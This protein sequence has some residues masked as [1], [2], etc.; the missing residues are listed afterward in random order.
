KQVFSFS[1]FKKETSTKLSSFLHFDNEFNIGDPSFRKAYS[2]PSSDDD[3]LSLMKEMVV[4]DLLEEEISHVISRNNMTL[5]S[6]FN[7]QNIQV[8]HGGSIPSHVVIDCD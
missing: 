1:T 5:A 8:M 7:Q 6:Y 2:S 4:T 3:K